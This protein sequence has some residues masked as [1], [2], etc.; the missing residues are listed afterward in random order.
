MLKPERTLVIVAHPDDAE[1]LTGGLVSLWTKGGIEVRY[2]VVTS[3]NKGTENPVVTSDQLAQIRRCEQ[4]RAAA[5][6]GVSDVIFLDYEDGE[7][8]PSLGLRRELTRIIR[9][10]RP[11]IV[12]TF[13][14]ETRFMTETYPNHPDH[15]ATGDA[16][17]DAVFPAARDRLTFPELLEQGYEPHK[18]RE[19][20]L[21][22]THN[23]THWVDVEP[24]FEQK[25]AALREHSSQVDGSTVEAELDEWSRTWA[26]GGPYERAEAF[27]R[28]VLD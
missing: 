12:V 5:R 21:V 10:W 13:D 20:W 2:V 28:I 18:V 17:V 6:L 14:P 1:Y 7:L 15:R 25:L 8:E 19:L 4:R 22:A 11:E 9:E 23:A 24:V 27:R 3:G 16:V 26:Q